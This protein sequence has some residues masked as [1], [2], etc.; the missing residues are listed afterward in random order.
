MRRQEELMTPGKFP[1]DLVQPTINSSGKEVWRFPYVVRHQ[2][3]EL[4]QALEVSGVE[5]RALGDPKTAVFVGRLITGAEVTAIINDESYRLI[6]TH[7]ANN[8]PAN[9][10]SAEVSYITPQTNRPERSVA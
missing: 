7:E 10:R 3:R 8:E 6:L 9:Q 1:V 5:R 4:L 2:S